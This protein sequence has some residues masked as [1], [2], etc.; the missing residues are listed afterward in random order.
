MEEKILS[1]LK[2]RKIKK[3][4]ISTLITEMKM[5]QLEKMEFLGSLKHFKNLEQTYLQKDKQVY[6]YLQVVS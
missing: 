1:W 6:S 3:I 4:A 5:N 2:R